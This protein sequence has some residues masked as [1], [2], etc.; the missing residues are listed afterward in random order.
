MSRSILRSLSLSTLSPSSVLK[1]LNSL[2]YPDMRKAMFIS[3]SYLILDGN[4]KMLNISRAGHEPLI[5]FKHSIGKIEQIHGHGMVLGLDDGSLF[6]HRID[7]VSVEY[8]LGDVFVLYTDGI[9]EATNSSD[10]E[11]TL[12]RLN[13]IIRSSHQLSAQK[14]VENI[15]SHVKRFAG[16]TP[17]SDDL[18][19]VVI[20]IE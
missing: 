20:K 5:H 2:I 6:N 9:T 17:Q 18:T 1:E 4:N 8:E 11:F 13:E 7:E 3:M 10:Q 15:C 16:D 19:L 14:I 12:E